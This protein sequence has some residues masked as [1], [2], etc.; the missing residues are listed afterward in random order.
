MKVRYT[1][2]SF[3]VILCFLVAITPASAQEKFKLKPGAKGKV[4]LSCH[5]T[6]EEKL[7]SPF[8]HTPVK[9]GECSG[10]HNPHASSNGK[11]L[12]DNPSRI[13]S[14]CHA[15]IPEKA[16]SVHSA[17]GKGQ[18]T[19]CHDPHSSNNKFVLLKSGNKLCFTCH[20][21]MEGPVEKARFKHAPVVKDCLNC[22]NPHASEKFAL[23]LKDAV[24][25]LCVKCHKTNAPLFAKQH[26][27]YPVATSRCTSCHAVHGSNRVGMF[28]ENVHKPVEG[29]MCNQCHEDATSPTPLKIK[30]EGN[31]LCRG[32]HS[33]MMNEMYLKSRIHWPVLSK[34]GCLACHNPHASTETGLRKAPMKELCGSC[35]QDT[36]DRQKG[37]ATKHLPVD[38]GY[39]PQC[40]KPHAADSTFLLSQ[41]IIDLCAS[42]HDWQKHQSH[43]MGAKVRDRRNKNLAVQCMSCHSAHGTDYKSMLLAATISEMCTQCH[44][45]Y[46]R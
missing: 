39:C 34:K 44:T 29:K 15:V 31:D 37:S 30:K 41:D 1:L 7:K 16:A 11:L 21:S 22:H 45:E 24:P 38:E 10:C 13:C 28:Y 18:C 33:N 27:N 6:F 43:P 20:G 46:R 4:C 36:I 3:A 32:C 25:S 23:L 40:H 8:V 9:A 35:H 5:V 17:I 12:V 19:I 42:C 2:W 14:R 26:M